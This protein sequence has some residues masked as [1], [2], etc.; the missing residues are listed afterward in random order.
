M[1]TRN[2]TM[3]RSMRSSA[4]I[5]VRVGTNSASPR[6]IWAVDTSANT[7]VALNVL[8][9]Q[10]SVRLRR[11]RAT[12]RDENWLVPNCTSIRTTEVTKPV[13]ASIPLPRAASA[14]LALEALI[15]LVT[16]I[17]S[18]SSQ[19]VRTTLSTSAPST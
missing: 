10:I 5:S 6:P 3:L 9:E 16:S 11:K 13:K 15:D 19:R 1:R 12:K 14:A 17:G 2:I 18:W 4:A 7:N 8:S